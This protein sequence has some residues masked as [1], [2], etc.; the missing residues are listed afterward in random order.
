MW[1]FPETGLT[2]SPSYLRARQQAMEQTLDELDFDRGLWGACS[3]GDL[4]RVEELLNV[5]KRDPNE[6]DLSDYTP[7]HYAARHGHVQV[8]GLLLRKRAAVDARAGEAAATPLHR[9]CAGPHVEVIATPRKPR[10]PH[11]PASWHVNPNPKP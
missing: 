4:G 1:V 5:R 3:R 2:L 8:C 10:A 7:L 11:P 6:R 9:A